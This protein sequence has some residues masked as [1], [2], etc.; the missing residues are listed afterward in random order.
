MVTANLPEAL[1]KWVRDQKKSGNFKTLTSV[2]IH[3]VRMEMTGASRRASRPQAYEE[4]I[5]TTTTTT[6]RRLP[7]IPGTREYSDEQFHKN[8][9]LMV[10]ELKE[11]LAERQAII[12]AVI[13]E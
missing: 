6:K 9:H 4:T 8:K 3:C 2:I 12:D 11:K 7:S 5:T 13:V 10:D 1:D